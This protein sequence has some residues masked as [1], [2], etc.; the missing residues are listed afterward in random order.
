ME[1]LKNCF[2]T[3]KDQEYVEGKVNVFSQRFSVGKNVASAEIFITALGIYE[4]EIDGKKIGDQFFAPGYT[5]YPRD[6]FY[7]K[8]NIE[9]Y[10]S[11]GE[12]ELKL[13]LGQGWYSGRFTHENQVKLY[14]DVT[15]VSWKIKICFDDG[16]CEE[17]F[18]DDR[19]KE[20]SSPYEYAGFYDGEIFDSRI[21]EKEIGEATRFTGQIPE[22]WSETYLKVKIHE[23]Q[24]I[25]N[26]IE[27]EDK[28]IIDFGQNFAGFVEV[29]LAMLPKDACI[30]LRHGEIL[31]KDGNLYTENLRKA[32]A[33]T[34]IY[35]NGKPG[36]YRPRFTY[37]G[38]RFVELTGISYQDGLLTA[39]TLYSDMTRTGFFSSVNKK[40]D[41]LFNNQLWGQK[42]NY[43]DIPT[44]CPQRDERMGY[45]GDGQA[46][47]L[48]GSYNFDTEDFWRKFFKDIRFSQ[49]DNSED[50][51]APTIPATG[52]GGIGFINM[53]GWGNAVTI[54][55]EMIYWQ[56][57]SARLQ[58]EQYESM[59]K[60]VNSEIRHMTNHLWL[61][62]NLGDWLIP[63][64]DMAWMAV[65]NGPVSN[66]FIV[67]D[68]KILSNL[69]QRLGYV[70]DAVY[71]RKQFQLTKEAY[72][73]QFIEADGT[74][75]G[76][77]QGAYVMALQ[78]ADLTGDI[79]QKVLDRLAMDVKKNGLNTGFFATEYLLPLLVEANQVELA[80]DV[81]L[82]ENCPGWMY[83]VNNGAT[84]IWERWDALK[85]DGSVN[86]VKIEQSNENMVSFNHYAF[87]SVGKFYYQFILGINP[88]EPGYR[89]I[90]IKPFTDKRLG[91]VSGR[92]ISRQGEIESS[93]KYLSDTIVE[94][95]I[96]T[97]QS[98]IIEL[99]NGDRYE[100][101][102]GEY[103]YQIEEK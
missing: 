43:I 19:V 27:K 63:G 94:F 66:A 46:Y 103:V 55:P 45:T 50:F 81:L 44:D 21:E 18:S 9:E 87:G 7:Q 69:A 26:I 51:V 41:R 35:G 10:L 57:G 4:A 84:T 102:S 70:E 67:N 1:E 22:H 42:S 75:F 76:D 100:V 92:F 86:D 13:Y 5:Y 24:A 14:G 49:M 80:F 15:A 17:M 96:K 64:K 53:L 61:A 47:A 58:E 37:M 97:P 28:T 77:Y 93:W 68:L 30:K 89:K 23:E 72:I 12:H 82:N 95:S 73:N 2:I 60:F 36:W 3:T 65:N 54:I 88:L 40:V 85:P 56:F 90:L 16:T 52:P 59:K 101:E 29:N 99:P 48:T 38:F 83:Q 32:K 31:T 62:P 34:I 74:L 78:Y 71:Y 39:K 8:F 11:T 20:L 33:E 6:L 79:R 25:K 98:T 91:E